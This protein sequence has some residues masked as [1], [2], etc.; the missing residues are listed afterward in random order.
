MKKIS[1]RFAFAFCV[2]CFT[3]G[4]SAQGV[5]VNSVTPNAPIINAYS[6]LELAVNLTAAYTN[7]Y[8]YSDIA[9]QCVFSSPSG[10]EYTV[11]GFFMQDYALNTSNGSISTTGNGAFK[12]RFTPVEAGTWQYLVSCVNKVGH[13]QSL[14]Q[15]FQCVA[16]TS[17]GY[18]RKNTSNYLNFDNGKQYIPVGE[19]M[20]WQDG[21]PYTDYTNWLGKLSSNGGNFIRVWMADWSFGLEWQNNN[22]GYL[23][24]KKYKQSN[25]YYLDWLLDKCA[26]S[27][28][29]MMLCLNHHG[30]VST[31]TNP[32]WANNPYNSA[33]G[34]P[35]T[36][37]WDFFTNSDAQD[38]IKNRLKYI[39]ARYG[40]ATSLMSWELFNEV[41]WTDNFDTYKADITNWHNTM[42]SY[43]R[44]LDVYSHLVTTSYANDYNDPNTWNLSSI[45]FT[46][47]HYYVTT[48]KIESIIA[49]GERNYVST[50][51]KPSLNGEFGLSGDAS[52]LGTTDPN[53]VYIHNAIWGTAFSGSMGSAMSWWWDN[54]I[55]TKNLYYHYKPLSTFVSTLKLKDDNYGYVNAT[56]TGAGAADITIS[57]GAGWAAAT[58]ASFTIDASGNINPGVGQLG[59]FVYGN[60]WNTQ[61][62]NPPTFNVNYTTA[63][64]FKVVV[65]GVSTSPQLQVY[66]D[67]TNV[68]STAVTANST[69]TVNVPAGQHAIKVDNLGTDW[70]QV[71]SYVFTKIG[72]PVTSYV[73]RS[74]ATDKAA[75][76]VVNNQ[77]NYQTLQA[78]GGVPPPGVLN[79]SITIP[80]VENGTYQ[81]QLFNCENSSVTNAADV[82]VTDNNLTIP[83][84]NVAWD[85]AF[86]AV[87]KAS[88]PV[89]LAKFY[90]ANINNSNNLYMTM[91][92]AENMR[93]II[94]ERGATTTAFST[95]GYVDIAKG[96]N[97]NHLFIDAQPLKG[98]NFYRLR[99]V[100]LDGSF[101]YSNS[102]LLKNTA[103]NIA[104][105]PNPV[106]NALSINMTGLP[107]DLYTITITDTGGKIL[108]SKNYNNNSAGA[109]NIPFNQ[110]AAGVYMV[111]ITNSKNDFITEHEVVK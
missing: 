89:T 20:G 42:A 73:L 74:S 106:K 32:E 79:A 23:G 19:D 93:S 14:A 29:Y 30:Q 78:N 13:A 12:V 10:K 24:L 110:Y 37:T 103:A 95:L 75:G 39:V 69:Y 1:V 102:I 54:Y 101:K 96:V 81:I 28:V 59:T 105:Y 85:V 72:S 109:L 31:T 48:P 64:Q 4:V 111:K 99:M 36:N 86:S 9:V 27:G 51:K 49:S 94:V 25:A 71:S 80:G 22:N 88:L 60:T 35:C 82:V 52:T 6:K 33:L 41:E 11:D 100:N 66:L 90:G 26:A 61:Y 56:A 5:T 77:Y 65:S 17:P 53:G 34:G 76:W 83:L 44:S 108:Q 15:F 2:L 92:N 47:T 55:E 98:D 45:D 7:P 38:D 58:A 67:G 62:R 91:T 87:N 57:P 21:N 50:Y 46:Q 97:G 16:A 3:I 70:I 107:H 63:A 104:F 84:G 43:I 68:L 40:Y 8:D 18:V